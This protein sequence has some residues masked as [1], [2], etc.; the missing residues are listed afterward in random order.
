MK[1]KWERLPAGIYRYGAERADLPYGSYFVACPSENS[2]WS[3]FVHLSH[4]RRLHLATHDT[5]EESYAEAEEEAAHEYP[6]PAIAQLG[7]RA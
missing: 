6:L 3:L 2:C 4:G 1:L 5:K 7:E